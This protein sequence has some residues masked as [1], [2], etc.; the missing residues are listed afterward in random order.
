MCPAP[1]EAERT[2]I[3][4]DMNWSLS[5]MGT[6]ESPLHR[7]RRRRGPEGRYRI[8]SR[9][10]RRFGAPPH[11]RRM[12]FRLSPDVWTLGRGPDGKVPPSFATRT[13]ISLARARVLTLDEG[14]WPNA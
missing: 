5:A 6:S 12:I 1:T 11:G 3:L 13:P 9:A 14:T 8:L 7:V 4:R 2:R 10:D